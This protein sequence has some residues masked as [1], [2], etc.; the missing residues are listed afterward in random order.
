VLAR[1]SFKISALSSRVRAAI[2]SLVEKIS[3]KH[4]LIL[5][6][7]LAIGMAA[8]AQ[9]PWRTFTSSDGERT[10]EGRLIA[11]N[12]ATQTISVQNRQGQTI[13][14][15][16]DL[17]TGEDREF[18]RDNLD[19]LPPDISLD[20]RFDR[21]VERGETN[22]SGD[23]R[24]TNSSGGYK[25]TLRNYT[26]KHY[27]DVEVDYLLIY[28]KD[29]IEGRGADQI[30]RGSE[31]VSLEANRTR[32]IET[33]TVSLTNFFERG[34]VSS[35]SGCSR[36]PSSNTATRSKRSKDF[37]VGCVAQIKVNGHVVT[38]TAT[39]ANLVREYESEFGSTSD[40][41]K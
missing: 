37:L 29:E 1:K 10:F 19:K 4:I 16:E 30:V 35:S 9:S 15:K 20:V 36:C 41:D 21:I 13:H 17:V 25:I 2:F 32:D 3:M 40:S 39:A 24:T 23:S 7:S 6:C 18:V 26:A 31:T 12:A 11:Y 5:A 28:R 27:S 8:H 34:K 14:F 22:R 33:Q 38:T